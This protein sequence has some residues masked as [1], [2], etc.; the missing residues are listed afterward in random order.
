MHTNEKHGHSISGHQKPH[1][2][3]AYISALLTIF[4]FYVFE[5]IR[6]CKLSSFSEEGIIGCTELL[7]SFLCIDATFKLFQCADEE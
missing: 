7:G 5:S 2:T 1:L 6:V 3:V 4:N